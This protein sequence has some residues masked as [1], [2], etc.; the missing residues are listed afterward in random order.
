VRR[1]FHTGTSDEP[2]LP[3][4]EWVVGSGYSSEPVQAESSVPEWVHVES[5]LKLN[6]QAVATLAV[7]PRRAC[8][9][10]EGEP[11]V[12][13]GVDVEPAPDL[14]GDNVSGHDVS[15]QFRKDSAFHPL[16]AQS[17]R[18]ECNGNRSDV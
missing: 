8:A 15:A 2:R 9:P 1:Q 6:P 14:P 17:S 3:L 13:A 16:R 5:A 18:T 7:V 12:R 10:K 4:G 11:D